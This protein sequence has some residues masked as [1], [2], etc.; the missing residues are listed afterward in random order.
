MA[1]EL[2]LPVRKIKKGNTTA[3]KPYMFLNLGSGVGG[4]VPADL[5]EYF[6]DVQPGDIIDFDVYNFQKTETEEGGIKFIPVSWA[7]P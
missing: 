2:S 7:R 6:K 5:M 3:G 4:F 1:L